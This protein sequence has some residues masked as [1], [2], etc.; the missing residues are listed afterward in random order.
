MGLLKT[1]TSKTTTPAGEK[2]TNLT[3]A[4]LVD[5]L[6]L[7]GLP[8]DALAE[9]TYFTCLRVLSEA[10]G[11]LPLKIMRS[12]PDQGVSE[13]RD[14]PLYYTLNRRPNPY[15]TAARFWASMRLHT[16]HYGN[17]FARIIWD[18]DGKHAQLWQLPS[19]EV[20]VWWDNAKIL[21]RENKL[22]Y[23]WTTAGKRYV[24]SYDEVIHL[25]TWL[26]LDT[27]TGLAVRDIL[28]A[29]LE[30][31]LTGQ[32]MLQKLFSSGFTAKAVV[33]FSA[34]LDK[35][36]Q[37][38]FVQTLENFANGS[39]DTSG[40][41]IPIPLGTDLTPLNLSLSDGQYIETKQYSALQVA[42]AFGVK[43]NQINDYTKSSYASSEAQQLAFLVDTLLYLITDDEQEITSKLLSR[44]EQDTGL[45][46][47]F[48]PGVLLRADTKTQIET[49]TTAI[50]GGLYLPNE[51]RAFLNMRAAEGGDK[52]L[53]NG[54]LI[55]LAQAGKQW[56][57]RTT[58]S[59]EPE[60]RGLRSQ[61]PEPEPYS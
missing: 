54:N 26:S 35:P 23:I 44:E 17:G 51:A 34:D 13:A 8:S 1:L 6:N 39:L 18:R 20:E 33:K 21:S 36:A 40:S 28:R 15:Q 48:N 49:L 30:T 3:L 29:T 9:A 50:S 38:K 42:A 59:T 45:F 4:Q 24:L 7:G 41:L 19:P 2:I 11:K 10:E 31:N 55:P 57:D 25:R 14:H 52:L 32:A 12:D 60:P 56:E 5:M 46:A 37:K 43:P 58:E 16:C 47:W 53:G 22:W 61:R 27:V